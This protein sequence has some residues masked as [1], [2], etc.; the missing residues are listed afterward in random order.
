MADFKKANVKNKGKKEIKAGAGAP[1]ANWNAA[2]INAQPKR[3]KSDNLIGSSILAISFS[4][5]LLVGVKKAYNPTII[6]K[7]MHERANMII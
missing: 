7:N 2:Q 5:L 6:C 4:F 1:H 3:K